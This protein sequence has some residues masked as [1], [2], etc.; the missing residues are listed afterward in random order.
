MVNNY[1]LII[2][3]FSKSF[4]W[5]QKEIY[6]NVVLIPCIIIGKLPL[7]SLRVRH[8]IPNFLTD[9]TKCHLYYTTLSCCI[10]CLTYVKKTCT[11][12][13]H[14]KVNVIEITNVGPKQITS[15]WMQEVGILGNVMSKF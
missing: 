8:D 9:K 1:T 6:E 5:I 2:V 7:A 15:K 13:R 11:E 10:G 12:C 14:E 3:Y 4:M